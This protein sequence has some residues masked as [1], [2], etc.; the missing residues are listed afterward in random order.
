MCA[1]GL[2]AAHSVSS[3]TGRSLGEGARRGVVRWG[4]GGM[5]RDE[6]NTEKRKQ[7]P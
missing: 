4:G 6:T 2:K 7:T 3:L 1:A 5:Q